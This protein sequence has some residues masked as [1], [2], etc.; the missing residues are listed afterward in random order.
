MLLNGI[1]LG[2]SM[3]QTSKPRNYIAIALIKRNGA[4]AHGKTN[5]AIRAYSRR[6][7][8]KE[9]KKPSI[10]LGGFFNHIYNGYMH[11]CA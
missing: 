1:L 10:Y 5:K 11:E 7:L 3:K 4:G 8:L 6:E 2:N 9:L